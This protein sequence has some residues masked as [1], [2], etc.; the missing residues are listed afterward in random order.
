MMEIRCT[1]IIPAWR[2]SHTIA[3]AIDSVLAQTYPAHEILVIDDGS[4]DDLD[5]ALLPYR[6][7]IRV[8]RQQNAGAAGARNL[9]IEQASGDLLAFLD[10]D[11]YWE[12]HKLQCHVALY[13]RFPQLGLTHSRY[14]EQSP[15]HGRRPIERRTSVICEQLTALHGPRAFE[16]ATAVWT[17]TVVVPR[18]II[19][20]ERFV[21]GLEPAEDRDLWVRLLVKAPVYCLEEPLAT[22][23]L[24]PSSLSRSDVTRDC[25]NMLKVVRRHRRLLGPIASCHWISH[26]H[27]R[28]SACTDRNRAAAVHFLLSLLW[29]PFPYARRRVSMPLARPRLL[30]RL[31]IQ[32]ANLLGGHRVRRTPENRPIAASDV[33][34]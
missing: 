13:V 6:G 29:W 34:P 32:F 3:R 18:Q 9:G 11:D 17:G 5:A 30:A 20:A 22:A 28:W 1:V 2:A 21:S 15:L 24:E 25:S 4:P 12:P 33:V 16:W 23:V 27:Y 19:G 8:L 7:R 31:L 10:A 14:S 26:T